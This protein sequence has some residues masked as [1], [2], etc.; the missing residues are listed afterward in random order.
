MLKIRRKQAEKKVEKLAK[1]ARRDDVRKDAMKLWSDIRSLADD[2]TRTRRRKT[3]VR[4]FAGAAALAGIAGAAAW[5]WRG[6]HDEA[7][8]GFGDPAPVDYAASK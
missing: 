8:M 4:T 3:R 1:V 2:V 7:A 5:A 6:R